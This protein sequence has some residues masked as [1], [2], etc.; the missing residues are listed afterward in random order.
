MV[1]NVFRLV[2]ARAPRVTQG[3]FVK[4]TSTNVILEKIFINV[5]PTVFVWIGWAGI[6]VPADKDSTVISTLFH[7]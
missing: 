3:L 1:V 5:V 7:D 6:I 2:N 4:K